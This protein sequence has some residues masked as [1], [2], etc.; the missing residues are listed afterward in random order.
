MARTSGVRTSGFRYPDE[1]LEEFEL[2]RRSLVFSV[3]GSYQ[4]L[5]RFIDS[6]E[7][8]DQFLILEEIGVSDSG[9]DSSDIRVRMNVSTLFLGAADSG[10][11]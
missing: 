10:K 11:A 3:E 8:S 4:Q 7:R 9:G 6:L 2:I 5:R 1:A